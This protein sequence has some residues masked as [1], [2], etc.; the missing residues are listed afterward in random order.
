M[1]LTNLFSV[2]VYIFTIHCFYALWNWYNVYR[3]IFAPVLLL[4]FLP[5]ILENSNFSYYLS[6]STTLSGWIQEEAK[7]FASADGQREHRAKITLHT[8]PL[9][10]IY[11]RLKASVVVM[12]C[13]FEYWILYQYMSLTFKSCLFREESYSLYKSDLALNLYFS[14]Y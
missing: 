10:M 7:L 6:L 3:A 12:H 2:L 11:S 1:A 5:W 8:V 13:N 9:I 4:V 14:H